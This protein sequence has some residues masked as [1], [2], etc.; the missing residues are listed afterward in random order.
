M[1]V[2][3]LGTAAVVV[4]NHGASRL[5]RMGDDGSIRGRTYTNVN[6][7]YKA[8]RAVAASV[9]RGRILPGLPD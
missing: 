7:K 1:S 4:G 9:Q 6:S 3:N 5:N 8:R 2:C